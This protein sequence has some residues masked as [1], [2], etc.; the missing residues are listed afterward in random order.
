M[1]YDVNN[2][3]RV[4]TQ[5]SPGGLAFANFGLAMLF[6]PESEKP[7]GMAVD[8]FRVYSN[9]SDVQAD[10]ADTT[11]TYKASARWLSM[12]PQPRELRIYVR[13]DLTAL[14]TVL[15]TLGK[16]ADVTWWYWTFFTKDVYADEA[17]FSALAVWADANSRF[18]PNC[19]VS[20]DIRNPALST[21][22]A[23]VLTTAGSRRTYTFS[24]AQDD[25]AGISLAALYAAVNYNQARSTITGEF[26]KLPGVPAES[27]TATEYAAMRLPTKKAVFYTQVDLQGAIDNG[28]V[29]NSITHSTF[30]E[31]VD[32]V[33]NLDAFVNN[34]KVSLFNAVA[35]QTTKL[36]Q[37]PAGQA[38]L[39]GAAQEVAEQYI[40]NGYLGPRNYTDP[41]DGV[42]KFTAG[43]EML[44][45]PEDILDLSDSE[46]GERQ[47]APIRLRVFR[48]GAVHLVDIN[49]DVY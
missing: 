15:T 5:L 44:T 31:Y 24:N 6:S 39:I 8:T 23:S 40:S 28:R 37:T 38:L 42:D 25:Y 32:D 27:L 7:A 49:V 22:I 10:F 21:D 36:P 26:K 47:S 13:S 33:V 48:A 9:L 20:A 12:I 46:R 43:Y 30:N 19:S 17:N 14:D 45:K 34:I 35:N 3:I 2:I 1:S 29:I 11:E 4:V 18:V 16:A 41:D